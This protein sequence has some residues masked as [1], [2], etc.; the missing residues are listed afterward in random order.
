MPRE[1]WPRARLVR[2][3]PGP[4]VPVR[5]AACPPL[6]T[7]ELRK[8]SFNSC[9]ARGGHVIDETRCNVRRVRVGLAVQRGGTPARTLRAI[10]QVPIVGA[11]ETRAGWIGWPAVND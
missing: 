4:S 2:A 5:A 3:C 6:L 8:L 10:M 7:F 1:T 9:L 11:Q